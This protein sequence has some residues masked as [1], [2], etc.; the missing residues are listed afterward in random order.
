[1]RKLLLLAVAVVILPA[2][3]NGDIVVLKDGS[4]IEGIVTDQGESLLVKLDKG[5]IVIPK[6]MVDRIVVCETPRQK[7]ERMLAETEKTDTEALKK[8]Q[9]W[10]GENGLKEEAKQLALKIGELVLQKRAASLDT[11]KAAEV[12]D[13]ALW[14]RRSG[15]QASIVESY[16]WKVLELDPDHAAA[17]AMLG[18]VKFR[19]QWLKKDQIEE[20]HLKEQE[21]EM[22]S[23]GMVNY[24][25]QW[26]KP[27]AAEYL[28][29]LE[30]IQKQRE[31]LQ[32]Q[33]SQVEE[34]AR[35]LEASRRELEELRQE[36]DSQRSRLQR[37]ED[38]L[39]RTAQSQAILAIRLQL[40]RQDIDKL[41]G[42]L[43]K[44]KNELELERAA[45]RAERAAI[46][47]EKQQPEKNQ[48]GAGRK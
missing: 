12:F 7:Y 27:D 22:R 14:C 2:V 26:L 16:L 32:Q 6:R 30:E 17:R 5:H 29:K 42:K 36:L 1:M 3:A 9:N 45:L 48:P 20:I 10:C 40:K 19:G 43:D 28:K 21:Q 41:Q 47:R 37:R 25:G 13:F 15:Y 33:R 23:K 31:D 18:H 11:N 34:Q 38:T 46:E 39:N 35:K 8:L 4:Q 24:K 44:L